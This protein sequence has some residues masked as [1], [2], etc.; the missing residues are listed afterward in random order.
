MTEDQHQDLIN[1]ARQVIGELEP[2]VQIFAD[3]EY[4]FME[5]DDGSGIW[6]Q[7]WVWVG[8]DE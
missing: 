8:A 5:T 3:D 6:V 2:D 7:A 1:R 4:I